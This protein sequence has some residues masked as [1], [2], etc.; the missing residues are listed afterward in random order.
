[1][2]IALKLFTMLPQFAVSAAWCELA[3]TY[4]LSGWERVINL[5]VRMKTASKIEKFIPIF[6]FSFIHTALCFVWCF[7]NQCINIWARDRIIFS[8][9]V[10]FYASWRNFT[11]WK[12]WKIISSNWIEKQKINEQNEQTLH[13]HITSK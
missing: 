11:N 6:C 8:S 7:N 10:Q 1:M 13:T 9:E 4:S 2:F 12:E 5:G 3:V